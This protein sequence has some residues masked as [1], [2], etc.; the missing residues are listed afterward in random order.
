MPETIASVFIKEAIEKKERILYGKIHGEVD[1]S[2][3]EYVLSFTKENQSEASRILG[4][5]RLTFRKR[6]RY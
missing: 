4:I 2:I 3:F 1:R 5:T 6:L